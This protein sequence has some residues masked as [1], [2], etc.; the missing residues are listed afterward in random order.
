[1]SHVYPSPVNWKHF[2]VARLARL[3]PVYEV[4]LVV[5]LVSGLIWYG[6]AF[7]SAPNIIANFLMIQAWVPGS[8]MSLNSPAWSLSVEVFLYVILFPCLV[9]IRRW[10]GSCAIHFFLL[11]A[12]TI[13][14]VIFYN[15]ASSRLFLDWRLPLLTGIAGFGAGFSLQFLLKNKPLRYP[16]VVAAGGLILVASGLLH[17][18]V[19]YGTSTSRM[20]GAGTCGSC[21]C[22]G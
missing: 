21:R 10:T 18:V 4:T 9:M 3:V 13:W 7:S 14:G 15:Y 19:F 20:F 16:P 1:M 2:F 22:L 11:S 5:A 17:K 6:S 12:G 8:W